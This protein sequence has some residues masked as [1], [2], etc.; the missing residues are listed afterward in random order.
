MSARDE[1]MRRSTIDGV[2]YQSVPCVRCRT[3]MVVATDA[4]L[5]AD[6][7]CWPLCTSCWDTLDTDTF[8]GEV[9]P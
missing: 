3:E 7:K 1:P 8:L 4:L 2:E 5:L 6:R 9:K